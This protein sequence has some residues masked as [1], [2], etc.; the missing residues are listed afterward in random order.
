[1]VDVGGL[2]GFLRSCWFVMVLVFFL[3]P[4][5]ADT[6]NCLCASDILSCTALDLDRVPRQL[7]VYTVM[8]DLSHNHIERLQLG[9][10]EGLAQL[11]TLRLAHN[12]VNGILP[13][14]FRNSSG[15]L[16]RHLDLSS[17]QLRVLEQH[18][19]QELSGLEELLLFNNQIT[20]VES[21][22]LAGLGN[23][24]KA[25]F[26]HNRLTDFPFFS[27]QKHSHPHLTMLDLS[28]NRLPK[29]PLED[30]SNLPLSIQEGLFLH[31]NSLV[32]ECSMYIL[33][34]SWERRGFA[35][36]RLFR[37]E[38]VC[39]IYG[40][41]RGSIR[42]FLYRRYFDKCNLMAAD[43]AP[44]EQ[45]SSVSVK[46]GAALLLHCITSLSGQGTTFFWM[47]PHE[48]YVVPPGNNV[49]LK[50]FA[51]G[52]LEIMAAQDQ[53]SGIYRCM[54][55]DQQRNET[56][57]VNV[58]VVVH[59]DSDAHE[60]FNTGY[61]TL[62]GC[63]VSLVLVLMYLYL[64]PC[65]CPPCL[66]GQSLGTATPSHVHEAGAESVHSSILTPTPPT[67]TEGP[68]RKIYPSNFSALPPYNS[69]PSNSLYL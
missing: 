19:F 62:L 2:A 13:G 65:H 17:N 10:F 69:H 1:M 68:G 31:N 36:V 12:R 57:E 44:L 42:F 16:L 15:S 23:L 43:N 11:E 3:R 67:T 66:K 32:C 38:H 4:V 51:N 24:R 47:A 37:H 55:Q 34:R 5:Q 7:P 35:S 61:T 60:S 22:A 54:A 50:M 6:G 56:R 41:Q 14:A 33:F 8:L 29:L 18:Y 26:S 30:V 28:S 53:D 58:T 46:A 48:D 39:L 25:Y 9:D 59:Y 45:E 52:S 40:I 20:H 64:T 27:I 49:S 21:Q 63:V